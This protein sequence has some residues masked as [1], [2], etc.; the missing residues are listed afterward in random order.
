MNFAFRQFMRRPEAGSVLGLLGVV[1]FF[2]VFGGVDLGILLGA[3]SWVN[4]RRPDIALFS[5]AGCGLN[6]RL[7]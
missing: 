1:A 5:R 7:N 4:F 2:V 6:Y 3:A